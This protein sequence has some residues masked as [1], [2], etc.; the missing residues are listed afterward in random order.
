MGWALEEDVSAVVVI[1]GATMPWPGE[2]DWTYRVLG[3]RPGGALLP[4]LVSAFVS[5]TYVQAALDSVFAPDPVPGGYLARTG[6]M[7]STRVETLRANARQVNALRPHVVAMS[8]R[9]GEV[10]LPV[11][12]LHGTADRT[13]YAEVHA[14]PLAA[15]LPDAN[16]TILEGVGH[17]PHHSAPDAVVDAI[18]RAA[19][20]AGL[21]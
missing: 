6:V 9:Y 12:I 20:R 11:E 13:V 14:K 16:L 8:A 21:R 3:S 1:S 19:A 15:L 2:V 18:N 17:M 4:A 7:M 5:E 10:S